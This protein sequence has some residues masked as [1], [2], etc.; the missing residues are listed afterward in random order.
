[1]STILNDVRLISNWVDFN[2]ETPHKICNNLTLRKATNHEIDIIKENN[3]YNHKVGEVPIFEACSEVDNTGVS[4]GPEKDKSS[5]KYWVFE[6]NQENATSKRKNTFFYED[7]YL[8]YATSLLDCNLFLGYNIK[9]NSELAS[10]SSFK[11]FNAIHQSEDK[12]NQP[13][14]IDLEQIL[15]LEDYWKLI[16]KRFKEDLELKE[17]VLGFF[18]LNLFTQNNRFK[19]LG[20]FALIESLI[21]HAPRDSGDSIT[22]QICSK[23]QLLNNRFSKPIDTKLFFKEGNLETVLKKI[24]AFRS[25]IAHG[26]KINFERDLKILESETKVNQFIDILLRRLI[27]QKMKEPLLINDLKKC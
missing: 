22:K 9:Y 20:K 8:Q 24:Y 1:M 6:V 23:V 3:L 18:N 10:T 26:N 17:V 21:T 13:R 25:S 5:W 12:P 11:Q 19:S 16:K 7:D 15:P 14:M 2:F 4:Y 27:I